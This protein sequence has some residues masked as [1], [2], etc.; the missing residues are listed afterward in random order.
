MRRVAILVL[1]P[2]LALA[3]VTVSVDTAADVH[4]ISP[5]I[6]GI[7]FAAD[8]DVATARLALT[9]WGGN[10]TTRYNWQIDTANTGADYFFENV[11]GCW[12]VAGNYCSPV[13][14]DPRSNRGANALL[15]GAAARGIAT[16]F[17]IPVMGWVAARAKYAHPFDCGCPRALVASQDAVDPYDTGCGNGLSAG[18]RVTCNGQGI[19]TAFGPGEARSWA[20]ALVSRFGASDGRRIYQLDN[21]PA[22][23]NSTHHDAHPTPTTYDELWTKS[24]DTALALLEA[25][26]T[27]QISGPAEWGWPAYFCSAADTAVGGCSP[28]SPD[29]AAHGGTELVAW[30]LQRARAQETASGKRVLHWL[31]L[32][33]YP[34]G[35]SA[36][37]NLRSLW[38]PAY[39]DPSWIGGAGISGGV[40]RL[41]P[42]MRDW[43]AQNYPGTR[44]SLSEYAWFS[45]VSGPMGPVVYAELLGLFGRERLDAATAWGGPGGSDTAFA[46]FK[47]FRNYD[48]AG[49]GFGDTSVRANLTSGGGAA[50]FAATAPGKVTIALVNEQSITQTAT[51][52]IA[53][54]TPSGAVQWWRTSSDAT[55]TRQPDVT[56]SGASASVTL[57]ARSIGMLVVP[58]A[59]AAGG[60][61]AGSSGGADAGVDGGTGRDG[62]SGLGPGIQGNDVAA[63]QGGC[64]AAGDGSLGALALLLGLGAFTRRRT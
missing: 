42:R 4:P 41:L 13:P 7:N 54:S 18:A 39:V 51:V 3:Q 36:P 25:D 38:D 28:T 34:Q 52:Q 61:D 47:L 37:D 19:S 15:A 5:L 16:L 30:Y 35:G 53:G 21:E 48:G 2:A 62:G 17:T 43:V 57:P 31:D 63:V 20:A 22:L 27:A 55:I 14:S 58:V 45:D 11:P 59:S 60:P 12:S 56:F 29:R 44:I 1:C 40:I 23:W 24:R 8:T 9:R 26:P 50:V 10:T 64:S 49:S 46:A 33:Y 6:Y 32:H